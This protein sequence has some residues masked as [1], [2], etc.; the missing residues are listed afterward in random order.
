[1]PVGDGNKLK[2]FNN[3]SEEIKLEQRNHFSREMTV[4]FCSREGVSEK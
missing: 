1:M 4:T 3:S 2:K